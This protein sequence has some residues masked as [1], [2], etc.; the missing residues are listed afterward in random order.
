MCI[1]NKGFIKHQII[2][3]YYKDMIFFATLYIFSYTSQNMK[4][5]PL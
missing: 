5:K 3:K 2:N 1:G 4:I